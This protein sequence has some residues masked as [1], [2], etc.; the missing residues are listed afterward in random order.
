MD[1]YVSS[2]T[3]EQIDDAVKAVTE[4]QEAWNAKPTTEAVN[5]AITDATKNFVTETTMNTAISNAVG[6]IATV[7]D[8]INGEVV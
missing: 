4:N 2:Y 6:N 1:D 3:G 7:L 5:T 8:A